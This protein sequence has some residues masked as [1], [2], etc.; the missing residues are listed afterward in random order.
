LL[1]QCCGVKVLQYSSEYARASV[2]CLTSH[3]KDVHSVG[4]GFASKPPYTIRIGCRESYYT[5]LM[6]I[7]LLRL[8]WTYATAAFLRLEYRIC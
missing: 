6:E 4:E 8:A 2:D 7:R 5:L 3:M 1:L